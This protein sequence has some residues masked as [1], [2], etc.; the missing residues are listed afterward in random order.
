[1][2]KKDGLEKALRVKTFIENLTFSK[3]Q[4]AGQ[5]FNLLPWQWEDVVL[6]A[7]GTLKKDGFRQY[8]FVYIEIPKKN[9]K[10]ELG[11]ALAL[12]L[13]CADGEG[14]PEVYSAAGD[15]EQ[16]GLVYEAAAQMVKNSPVLSK[17]LKVLDSRKRI[18]N[19]RNSGFYQV[20]S[21]ESELQHGLS[22][23]AIIFDE[24][25]AQPTDRLWNVLTAGTDYARSQQLVFVL[26]TAGIYDKNSIWWKIR[27][28]AQQIEKGIIKQPDFLPVLYIADPET[29]NPDD[30]ELW[31]RVNPSIGHIFD[32]DKI[33][34]D[35]ATA[36]N[37]PVDYQNFL[38]FR[39]NIP[40]KS[41]SRWMPMDKWDACADPVN[42]DS[43]KGRK[44]YGGLDLASK[45]DLAAFVMVFPPEADGGTWDILCKFYCPEEGIL[46]RSR[47]D[48]V[49]YDIWSRQGFL[50]ST[51]GDCID[52][53]FIENDIFQAA[54]D[55]DLREIGFDS[56]NATS[57]AN[58]VMEKL[59]PTNADNGFRMMEVRQGAKSFNEPAK[60]L[61]VK[62]M[63]KQIRH[64]GNPVL[65]WCADNLVMRSDPNGNVAPDKQK[66]R[67]KIDGMVA[68]IMAMSGALRHQAKEVEPTITWI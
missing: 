1:M 2:I 55:Y 33:R 30:E 43:L 22:P 3:G 12:Y 19:P 17:C 27:T 8:R 16:A 58:R 41:L 31:R 15:R 51:P 52:Y 57:T 25:H 13:L 46:K 63:N 53:N 39:L 14:K 4:W 40:I 23:S 10:S 24:L 35:Y 32:I 47:I 44:A 45:N 36:K 21:S 9:G 37:D 68:L 62:V 38:R 42:L 65:R 50:T 11:A 18:I 60:D 56:W 61:L 28:R 48:R 29:D 6:P 20:L 64:G 54:K 26:T 59:N 7:F 66:A 49:N 67:D 34:A 5:P